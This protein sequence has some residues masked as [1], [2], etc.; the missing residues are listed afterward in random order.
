VKQKPSISHKLWRG[1][2]DWQRT[3]MKTD[4]EQRIEVREY[5][6]GR[7]A[8]EAREQFEARLM[9]DDELYEQ[10]LIE[11]DELADEYI[12]DELKED[13]R[14]AVEEFF[15]AVPDGTR[16]VAFARSLRRHVSNAAA[17]AHKR[18]FRPWRSIF[19]TPYVGAAAAVVLLLG[20]TFVAWRAFNQQPELDRGL[21]ALNEAYRDGRPLEARITDFAYAPLIVTRGERGAADYVA[22]SR[23]ERLLLDAVAERPGP[24]A[25]HALGRYYLAE[26]QFDRA[27]DQFEK[28]TAADSAHAKAHADLGAALLEAGRRQEESG[29]NGRA[30]ES[31]ARSL[32]HI[33]RAL[34]L[35]AGTLAPLFNRALILERMGLP[36]EA[37]RASKRSAS[38]VAT[39]LP[40]PNCWN[41][42]LPQPASETQSGLGESTAG[43]GKSSRGS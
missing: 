10:M 3:T 39:L 1:N 24:D 6:L 30:L 42:S 31:Y 4:D 38:A 26:R 29:D 20:L 41:I 19:T 17:P 36:G 43:T 11:E 33:D 13:E 2:V 8:D 9:T 16:K 35:E 40:R 32:R 7:L 27:V 25:Y 18:P 23:A 34:E 28:A 22:R 15:R 14:R 5:L 21:A 37:R 12:G